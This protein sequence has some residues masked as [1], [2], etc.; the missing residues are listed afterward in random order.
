[1]NGLE[2]TQQIPLIKQQQQ[3]Q[4]IIIINLLYCIYNSLF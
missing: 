1:M 4:I 2:T 3:Q